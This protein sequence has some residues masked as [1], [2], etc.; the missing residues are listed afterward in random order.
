MNRE[1]VP[2]RSPGSHGAPW[3]SNDPG[4]NT[5]KGFHKT[6][7]VSERRVSFLYNPFRVVCANSDS[8]GALVRPWAVLSD[9]FRVQ[10]FVRGYLAYP[11]R[12]KSLA[13]AS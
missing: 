11:Q 4:Q 13:G 8:Q 9:P 7:I 12:A 3:E 1:A 6:S 2:Q 5:L 10:G